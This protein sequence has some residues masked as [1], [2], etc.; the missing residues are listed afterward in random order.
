M[1]Y[2][3]GLVFIVSAAWVSAVEPFTAVI[4][5]DMTVVRSGPGDNP[6]DGF[7]PVLQLRTGDK[8]DV[9][10]E[11]DD[12]LAIRPPI[13][14]FSWV[15]A[16]YVEYN[17]STIGTVLADGLA[18][19]V[20][21]NY[22]DDCETVQVTLNKGE[23]LHILERREMPENS[24]SPIWLKIAPPSGE[25]R[26]IHK[27]AVGSPIRQV[28][29]ETEGSTIPELPRVERS[30][31][32][33]KIASA[34]TYPAIT[35]TAAI[36]PFQRAFNELQREAY[37]VMTRPTDDDVFAVLI[38]RAAE[39]HQIAPS[40]LDLERTYHLLES[41]QRTR[42]VRR[43]LAL[44]RP[45]GYVPQLP[46]VQQQSILPAYTP[47][48]AQSAASAPLRAGENIGGYDFVGRLG[49]FY[50]RPNEPPLPKEHPPYAVVDENGKVICM[51]TPSPE[52]DL[53]P[54]IG[55]F[56]GINGILGRYE[57]PGKPFARHITAKNIQALR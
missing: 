8:V 32:V 34:Q 30:I 33:P 37:I 35:R 56:V 55:K 28:R 1:R 22:S 15:S 39:L 31:P 9:Y 36:N 4:T 23:A 52:L 50:T 21:S 53:L 12:W 51:I 54:H 45:V 11:Q 2:I 48:S 42:T 14:S 29:H 19:R 3:L 20:G 7:Y 18:S 26:W 16:K 57:Q 44:R 13:G 24:T 46:A 10:Y 5:T 25:F 6:E 49:E 43:D 40:D 27:S 17:A 41:L 38:Q 47:T